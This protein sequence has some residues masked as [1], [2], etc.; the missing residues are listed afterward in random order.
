[1]PQPALHL[2]LADDALACWARDPRSAPFDLSAP[3]ACAAFLM[4]ALAPDMGYFP[5]GS[6]VRALSDTVHAGGAT[7]IARRLIA[8]DDEHIRAFGAGWMTHVLADVRIHPLVNLGGAALLHDEGEEDP[9]D[10]LHLVAHI[11]V[12][13]GLEGHFSRR[14]RI[15]CDPLREVFDHLTL[16]RVATAITTNLDI[17]LDASALGTAQRALVSCVPYCEHLAG[18][19][20]SDLERGR[21]DC[22]TEDFLRLPGVRKVTSRLFPRTSPLFGFLNPVRPP[23]WLLQRVDAE[24]MNFASWFNE[25]IADGLAGVPDFDLNTGER[26]DAYPAVCAA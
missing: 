12:E 13:L 19:L 23:I 9:D 21:S 5:G 24:V 6:C 11:R 10:E 25:L 8:A 15:A 3:D 20:A 18:L 16:G 17:D 2:A 1:M 14:R 4:G 7:D 22:C 26:V